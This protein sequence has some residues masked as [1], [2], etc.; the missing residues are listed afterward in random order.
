MALVRATMLGV[1]AQ[2][3]KVKPGKVFEHAGPLAS[4]M[5]LVEGGDPSPAPS[6]SEPEAPAPEQKSEAAADAPPADANKRD[7]RRRKKEAD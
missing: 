5:E 2:G 4:W 6:K 7:L 3:G 1:D